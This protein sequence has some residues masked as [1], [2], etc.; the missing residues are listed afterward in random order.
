M[1]GLLAM[2]KQPRNAAYR[3]TE[4]RKNQHA[5]GQPQSLSA[6]RKIKADEPRQ[7][8]PT[9]SQEISDLPLAYMYVV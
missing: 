2:S 6:G 9:V 5:V 3:K 4:T 1:A 8:E 7:R